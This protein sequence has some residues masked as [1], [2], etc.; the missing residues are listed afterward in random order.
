MAWYFLRAAGQAVVSLLVA[1]ALIF[2]L[3]RVLP[4]DAATVALG[5]NATPDALAAWR[6]ATGTDQ[7]LLI[8]YATWLTGLAR[9]DF[10]V[11]FVT[12]RPISPFVLDRTQVTLILVGL[13]M[14]IALLVAVPLGSLAA[15]HRRNPLGVAIT[16]ASQLGMAIPGFLLGLLLVALFSVNLGW[17]PAGGWVPP[18]FGFAEFLRRVTLPALTLGVIQGAVLTRYVRSAVI[19]QLDLDYLRT[20]RA[21]GLTQVQAL[22]RH[23]LRNAAIPVLTV[24]GL[25]TASMLIGAVVIERVF[26]VPGL[27]SL[28]VDAVGNRD[29]L[30]VQGI[31][32]VLVAIIIVVNFLTE[33]AYVAIDP[34]LRLTGGETVVTA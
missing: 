30:T 2:L 3:L 10:G 26:R 27:G 22:W 16:G 18:A 31:V 8:Q 33:L 32:M 6:A 19:E 17:L 12:G 11:S 14:L 24:S 15:L 7:P 4:G 25:Q 1:S 23:G 34:R 9:L 21:T 28:L 20:A 13:A 29:L 5:V